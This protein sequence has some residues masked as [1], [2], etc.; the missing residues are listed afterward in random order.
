MEAY[1]I[2]SFIFACFSIPLALIYAKSVSLGIN[3][4]ANAIFMPLTI[5]G[6]IWALFSII[7]LFKWWAFVV[8]PICWA[9]TLYVVMIFLS[10]LGKGSDIRLTVELRDA[11]AGYGF[12]MFIF[13][14]LSVIPY[15]LY[16]LD[17]I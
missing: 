8:I 13:L 10:H 11:Q 12:F 9:L 16:W 2:I 3:R 1:K 6:F 4:P 15:T 14:V 5:G 17:F 7:S